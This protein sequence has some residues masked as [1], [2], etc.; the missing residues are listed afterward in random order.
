MQICDYHNILPTRQKRNRVNDSTI[1]SSRKDPNSPAWLPE[2]WWSYWR[3]IWQTT[4]DIYEGLE[5]YEIR[6]LYLYK[7]TGE[8]DQRYATRVYTSYLDNFF[9]DAID[10]HAGIISD[11]T[12]DPESPELIKRLE[13]NV[14]G[15]GTSLKKFLIDVD[16]LALKDDC[17]FIAIDTPRITSDRQLREERTPQLIA[18]DIRD[19]FA[20]VKIHNGLTEELGQISIRRTVTDRDGEFGIKTRNQF[21]VYKLGLIEIWDENDK[22]AFIKADEFP[23]LNAK[24]EPHMAI[25]LVWYSASGS[26]LLEPTEPPFLRL[27]R[28]N[29]IHMNKVSELDTA[30]SMVNSITKYRIWPDFV[31]DPPPD[32]TFGDDSIIDMEG[33]GK[34]GVVEAVGNGTKLTQERIAEREQKMKE[35][36]YSFLG[37]RSTP[38]T[39]TEALMDEGKIKTTLQVVAHNKESALGK[40]FRHVMAFGDSG[41]DYNDPE[42]FA[43]AIRVSD[44]AISIPPTDQMIATI[45]KGFVDGAYGREYMLTK[46]D[47]IGFAPDGRSV[48]E[49]L[50]VVPENGLD[51]EVIGLGE[52]G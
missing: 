24:K 23:I 2:D 42:G 28:L 17:C 3:P 33:G 7:K 31:P 34:V 26:P 32:Q 21:W 44:D 35:L 22:G 15:A 45:I 46:L 19:V 51:S 18:I 11:Y 27:L 8:R 39:A 47:E 43:G 40:V 52:L 38:K 50:G 14:D 12:L 4:Q 37:D 16:T 10:S 41:F 48:E 5:D 30:E 36:S 20:P 13:K 6:K 29:I 25:P 9:R 1:E 49:E